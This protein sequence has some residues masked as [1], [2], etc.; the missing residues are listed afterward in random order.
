M[1]SSK[2]REAIINDLYQV[3]RAYL[4]TVVYWLLSNESIKFF[5]N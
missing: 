3:G 5:S 2:D 4:G 1:E